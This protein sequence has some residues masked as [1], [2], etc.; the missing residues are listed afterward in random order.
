MLTGVSPQKSPLPIADSA[1]QVE[2][3][4]LV[5]LFSILHISLSVCHFIWVLLNRAQTKDYDGEQCSGA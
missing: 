4:A 2:P 3:K 1:Q 5:K